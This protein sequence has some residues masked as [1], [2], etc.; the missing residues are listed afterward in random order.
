MELAKVTFP[1]YKLRSYLDINKSAMGLVKVT[2]IK[3]EFILDDSSFKGTLPQ[4][5]VA[6]A[7]YYP[8][9][10]IY[11]LSEQVIYLRQLVKYRSGTV[12]VDYNG[13]LIKYRKSSKLYDI[14]SH[15]ITSTTPVKD[16]WTVIKL[17]GV[18]QSLLV[19]QII[20]RD[21][22]YAA[23]MHTKWGPFLYDLTSEQHNPYK[24]KI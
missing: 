1:L 16:I 13:N 19:G 5:R 15:K 17:K 8:R 18:E 4:R 3:G 10:R 21:I 14:T 24:R 11:K 20:T 22:K 23:I 6:L 12:F 7:A 2:T 9:E